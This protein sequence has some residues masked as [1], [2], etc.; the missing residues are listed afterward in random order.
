MLLFHFLQRCSAESCHRLFEVLKPVFDLAKLSLGIFQRLPALFESFADRSGPLEEEFPG[1]LVQDVPQS[2][3]QQDEV[4]PFIDCSVA[5]FVAAAPAH[6]SR[7]TKTRSAH[8]ARWQPN[9]IAR[10]LER[11]PSRSRGSFR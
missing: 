9:L 2:A 1:R 7:Q 6:P 4:D 11:P 8:K 3:G 5:L 10:L